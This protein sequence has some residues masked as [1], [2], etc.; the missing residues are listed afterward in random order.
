MT[1]DSVE[2]I[3]YVDENENFSSKVTVTEST[4]N[5]PTPEAWSVSQFLCATSNHFKSIAPFTVYGEISELK[6]HAH[7]Y[8]KLKDE[9]DGSTVDCVMWESGARRLYF[10]PKIGDRV[11]V[12]GRLSLYTKNGA[13]KF[14]IIRMRR[15]GLGTILE[16]LQFLK[17]KLEEQGFF[18]REKRKIPSFVNTVGVITSLEGKAIRDI[19]TTIN[20]RNNGVHIVIYNALVQGENAR[21]SLVDAISFANEHAYCDVLIIGRG[22]GSVEDLMAFSDEEV[23]KA[24]ALSSI[25]IISAVG[26]E[27]DQMLTDYAADVRAATPTRAAEF[28]TAVT[29]N[30]IYALLEKK[31]EEL[32]D[33]ILQHYDL[34]CFHF[35]KV[36]KSFKAHDPSLFVDKHSERLSFL[37]MRSYKAVEGYLYRYT[38]DLNDMKTRLLSS[39]PLQMIVHYDVRLRD[40]VL[41]LNSAIGGIFNKSL[42][43]LNFSARL[44]YLDSLIISLQT[45]YMQRLRNLVLRLE[46]LDFNE[47]HKALYTKSLVLISKLEGLN[48]LNILKRG[49]TITFDENGQIMDESRLA[50][51]TLMITRFSGYE[52]TS[53]IV[54]VKKL[55]VENSNSK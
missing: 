34:L 29:K 35:D 47:K 1:A 15:L 10:R 36:L 45:V 3:G 20:H 42:L 53:R 6:E 50:E 19:V 23:V 21:K 18:S 5:L 40:K 49:Y 39:E 27:T 22:G 17:N 44:G 13:F 11:E 30:E 55:T 26:H 12:V 33:A 14:N 38:I 48:P 43:R 54:D 41:K 8:F 28:V 46:K 52:T 31:R 24:V 32:T 9:H 25:P 4:S 16:K 2:P 51:N 7:L 37:M